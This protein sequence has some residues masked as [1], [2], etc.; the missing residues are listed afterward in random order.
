MVLEHETI[1]TVIIGRAGSK[2]LPGKNAMRIAGQSMIGWTIDAALHACCPSKIIVSTDGR[3]IADAAVAKNIRAFMRPR[4]LASDTAS[5]DDAVRHAVLNTDDVAAETIIILYANVP[6]RPSDLIERALHEYDRNGWDSVQSYCPVG[7]YHPSWMVT[8]AQ[9]GNVSAYE[10][11]KSHRRQDLPP[12]YIPDG[13]VIVVSRAALFS[14]VSGDPASFLGKR[15]GSVVTRPGDVV[16]V[17]DMHDFVIA[18]ALLRMR[19][20]TERT[21]ADQSA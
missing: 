5:I 12:V 15:R 1:L 11:Q 2:G 8:L 9:D 18:E 7:K 4:E 16:D 21:Y 17:D 6:V 3:N 13:G 19:A 10:T 14:A 20:E